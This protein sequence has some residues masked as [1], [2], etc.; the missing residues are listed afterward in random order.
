MIDNEL[1]DVIERKLKGTDVQNQNANMDENTF[2]GK[3]NEIF[4]EV[5]KNYALNY[6]MSDMARRNHENNEIYIHDL[7]HYALGDHNCLTFPIDR[8]L[9]EG[10]KTRQ[11][12]VRPAGSLNTAFQLVA[13][14][15]QL[16]SLNQFGGV[17]ASHIDWSMVPYVRKSF[18]KHYK[19]GLKYIA[20]RTEIDYEIELMLKNAKD[21]SIEDEEYKAYSPDT[22]QYAIDMTRKECHQSVEAMYHNLNTL[23]SRSGKFYCP[24]IQ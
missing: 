16:Q 1:K 20:K 3:M 12:D 19:D 23:Q 22:W 14:L 18:A 4:G 11:T 7:D 21:Y 24:V 13:V 5:A 9:A 15:F 6:L 17:S 8:L 10:F 2:G